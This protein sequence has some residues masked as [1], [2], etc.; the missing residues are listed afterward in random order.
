MTDLTQYNLSEVDDEKTYEL[1]PAGKYVAVLASFEERNTLDDKGETEKQGIL[2]KYQ[3]LEEPHKGRIVF[4]YINT[5]HPNDLT[6]D[7]GRKRLKALM[8][9]ANPEAKTMMQLLDKAVNLT[10]GIRPA[11]GEYQAKN[12]VKG[13]ASMCKQAKDVKPAQKTTGKPNWM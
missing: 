4:D 5:I 9:A 8:N 12:D 1:I 10:V 3:L 2:C 7:I 13:I 6:Q 11:Q